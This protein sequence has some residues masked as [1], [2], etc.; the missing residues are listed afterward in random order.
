MDR[1]ERN[2]PS[3][4]AVGSVTLRRAAA[5]LMSGVASKLIPGIGGALAALLDWVEYAER[6]IGALRGECAAFQVRLRYE[7]GRIDALE[8]IQY[9]QERQLRALGVRTTAKLEDQLCAV[10][11]GADMDGQLEF[12]PAVPDKKRPGG[13]MPG[14]LVRPPER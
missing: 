10:V 12:H 7:A 13:M 6:E 14:D 4:P 5:P 8:R 1:S 11:E 2:E 3:R 9:L